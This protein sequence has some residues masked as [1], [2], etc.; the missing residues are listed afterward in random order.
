MRVFRGVLDYKPG[1]VDAFCL[2]LIHCSK[3]GNI[4]RI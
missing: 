2:G 3:H 1:I 4:I